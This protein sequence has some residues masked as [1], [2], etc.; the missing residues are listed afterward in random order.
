[1]F[2]A[3][4]GGEGVGKSTQKRLLEEHLPGRFPERTFAFTREP[5]GSPYAELIRE[6]ILRPEAKDADGLTLFGLYTAAR[7]DHVRNTIGPMLESGRVVVT[8][9]FV[10][11]TFAYQVCAMDNPAS[12]E[13]FDA[14]CRAIGVLPNLTI[15]LDMDPAL[16]LQR[17]AGRAEASNHLDER[18]LEFHQRLREGYELYG[19]VATNMGMNVAVIDAA[20]PPEVVHEEILRHLDVLFSKHPF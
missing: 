7:A 15:I 11:S 16:A 8:D 14:H 6:T 13:L 12:R 10:G 4:E 1:M 20:R 5:G 17:L 18:G 2:I 19:R 9:R 3:L